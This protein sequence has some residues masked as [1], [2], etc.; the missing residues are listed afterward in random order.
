MGRRPLVESQV[1]MAKRKGVTR[2]AVSL[3]C[4]PGGALHPALI[5][6]GRIDRGHPAALRWLR[7]PHWGDAPTVEALAA[8]WELPVEEL[9]RALQDELREAAVPEWH[10][11]LF[12]FARIAGVHH[13]RMAYQIAQLKPALTRSCYIDVGHPAALAYLAEHPFP[14]GPNGDPVP[15]EDFPLLPCA[16]GD[17]DKILIDHP[18]VRAFLARATGRVL[19][20][21]ELGLGAA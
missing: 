10:V 12:T 4:R 8:E 17:A 1:A 9:R 21:E 20:D 14:R 13:T 11:G 7:E 3:A 15:P 2:G 19:T 5:G 18:F 16:D 6:G